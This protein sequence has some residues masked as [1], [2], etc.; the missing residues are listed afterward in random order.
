MTEIVVT[1]NAQDDIQQLINYILIDLAS[2]I[3]PQRVAQ[4]LKRRINLLAVFPES[5]APLRE[6]LA[7]RR[8]IIS[9]YAIIY[10]YDV[11]SDS[12]YIMHVYHTKQQYTT[13][14]QDDQ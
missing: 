10:R 11:T 7:Y 13:L 14:F 4:Q 3:P 5:G 8:V 9:V 12:I 2:P 1:Q 6:A